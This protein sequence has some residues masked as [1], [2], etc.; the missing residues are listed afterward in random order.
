MAKIQILRSVPTL[1]G[2]NLMSNIGGML[3]LMLGLGVLQLLQLAD[4]AWT[5]L[6]HWCLTKK[7][8][9]LSSDTNAPKT[10][11]V[12]RSKEAPYT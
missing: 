5:I 12:Q 6:I 8:M 1:S 10:T 3:G 9:M 4:Q 2:L 11:E 7:A